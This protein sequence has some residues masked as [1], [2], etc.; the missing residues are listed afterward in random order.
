MS[1]EADIVIRREVDVGAAVDHGL[2]A[3]DPVMHAKKRIGDP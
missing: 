2:G 3:G 1:V